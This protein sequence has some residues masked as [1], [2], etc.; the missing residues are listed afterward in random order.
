[1]DPQEYKL[2]EQ[3]EQQPQPEI[4]PPPEPELEQQPEVQTQSQPESQLQFGPETQPQHET[5][6]QEYF[7]KSLDPDPTPTKPV[8][9]KKLLIIG[10]AVAAIL[11][12]AGTILAIILTTSNSKSNGNQSLNDSSNNQTAAGISPLKVKINGVDYNFPIPYQEF[13]DKGW[14]VSSNFFNSDQINSFNTRV[15]VL[16]GDHFYDCTSTASNSFTILTSDGDK[17]I[18]ESHGLPFTTDNICSA[19]LWIYNPKDTRQ[20]IVNTY[21]VGLD[22]SRPYRV[23]N[24]LSL[25]D[26]CD[27]PTPGSIV[28]NDKIVVGESNWQDVFGA[29]S[30]EPELGTDYYTWY[31]DS[32]YSD[33]AESEGN[34][35]LIIYDND[36]YN[37][38]FQ[39]SLKSQKVIAVEFRFEFN[40]N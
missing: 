8:R 4:T 28:I 20:P 26:I 22:T 3:S 17:N 36:S 38:I 16:C 37:I 21:V 5:S 23:Y 31:M 9:N 33:I 27:P 39:V 6:S 10:I 40:K 14:Q 7:Y 30:Q 35:M 29:F 15:N 1:M 19:K 32:A 2:Q 24:D 25:D 18:N 34:D 13:M 12:I 11:V